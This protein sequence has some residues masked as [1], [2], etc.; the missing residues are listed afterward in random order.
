MT[1][2]LWIGFGFLALLVVFLMYSVI[3]PPRS[4]DSTRATIRFLTALCA[5]FAGGFLTGEALI[6]M[7]GAVGSTKYAISGAA[8][9]ALFFTVWFFYDQVIPLRP[10]FE[11]SIPAK[12]WTFRNAADTMAR[13]VDSAVDF[14][15]FSDKELT[16]QLQERKI[17]SKT[18]SE[19]MSQL[20]LFTDPPG[21]IREYDV[22]EVGSIYQ[23][24]VK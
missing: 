17:S 23:L 14:Q 24:K 20:R 22:A 5:G 8:G 13:S 10:G 1:I 16:A 6:H 11:F 12:N 4:A 2:Q 15:G 21:Q 7:E 18:V 9:T 19:A 3:I